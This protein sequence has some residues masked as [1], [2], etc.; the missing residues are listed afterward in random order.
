MTDSTKYSARHVA[1]LAL[2]R[3]LER[4]SLRGGVDRLYRSCDRRLVYDGGAG[5]HEADDNER[6]DHGQYLGHI[7][8]RYWLSDH[9]PGS[10]LC[11]SSATGQRKNV[12]RE[13]PHLVRLERVGIRGHRRAGEP[14]HKRPRDV[15]GPRAILEALGL[16]QVRRCDRQ[17]AI[18]LQGRGRRPVAAPTLAVT[19]QALGVG[20]E[21]LA[22]AE[23][24]DGDG[25]RSRHSNGLNLPPLP[26]TAVEALDVLDHLE[27]LRLWHVAEARHDAVT[28]ETD[29]HRAT[30]AAYTLGHGAEQVRRRRQLP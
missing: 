27:A 17:I 24:L 13:V 8:L 29:R 12:E 23:A 2:R 25:R 19:R 4:Q 16:G 7:I 15:L 28:P 5:A 20:V 11:R 1:G 6:H 30:A 18:V 14:G 22:A 3:S 9:S 21:L 26:E 10:R